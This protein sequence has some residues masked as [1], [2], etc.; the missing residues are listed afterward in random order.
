MKLSCFFGRHA[1][2]GCVCRDCGETR[3]RFVSVAEERTEPDGCCWDLSEP[4]IGPHCGVFCDNYYPGRAG[5]RRV[6]YRCEACGKEEERE[7]PVE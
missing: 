2:E 6:T 5:M 1:W 4:C 3:H 7:E